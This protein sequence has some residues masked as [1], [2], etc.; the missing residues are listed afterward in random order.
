MAFFELRNAKDMLDKSFRE[1]ERLQNDF[2]IDNVFNYFVTAYHVKDYLEKCNPE[3]DAQIKSLYGEQDFLDCNSVCNKG[4][5]FKLEHAN[6]DKQEKTPKPNPD[7]IIWSGAIGGAPLNAMAINDS[8]KWI[9]VFA[10][11]SRQIDIKYLA[12]RI[13]EKLNKFFKENKI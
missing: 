7:A 6:K 1:Y 10:E 3:L 2:T 12:E 9:L 8:D 5:H 4:K 13:L 11:D